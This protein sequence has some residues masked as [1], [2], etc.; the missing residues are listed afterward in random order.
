MA[1]NRHLSNFRGAYDD[2]TQ[3]V[4]RSRPQFLPDH[5]ENLFALIDETPGVQQFVKELE[6]PLFMSFERW[7]REARGVDSHDRSKPAR[8]AQERGVGRYPGRR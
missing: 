4:E 7:F 3:E 5:L 8:A 2:L 1:L 6:R